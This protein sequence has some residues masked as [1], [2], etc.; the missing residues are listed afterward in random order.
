LLSFHSVKDYHALL[1]NGTVT[2]T[3]AVSFYI[4]NIKD[5]RHLNA[6][7]EVYE[8]EAL[9]QA[10][11]LDAKRQSGK[12]IGK[13]HGVI[14]GLKDVISYKGHALSA[15][16]HILENFQ[17][18]YNATVVERLL[19]EDAIIIGR[20]NCDEFAMGSSNENSAFGPVL[21]AADN[22]R[23]PGGSSGGSAVAVQADLCMVSLGSDTGGSVRQP[24]DFCGIVGLKPSYGRVSRYGLIA[25]GSSF[26]QI[27]IFAKNISDAALVLEIIS[28]KDEYDST[29]VDAHFHYTNENSTDETYRIG[30]FP[31]TFDHPSLDGEIA[32]QQKDFISHLQKSGITVFPIDFDLLDYIVPAYYILTTAEASSNLS[33]YDGIK[34]GVNQPAKEIDDQIN[35]TRSKFFGKEVQRRIMLGTFVLSEGYY[36]AYVTQA[37]RVRN[38]LL[39]KVQSVFSDVDAIIFPVSPTTAFRI[40]EK[41]NDPVEMFLADIYTVFANLT[42]IPAVSIPLFKHSDGMPFGVQVMASHLNELS[43]LTLSEKLLS[44]NRAKE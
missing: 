23:V 41:N 36:D 31:A 8:V 30:Y 18:V 39:K 5:N 12:P 22:S 26:D 42:G 29:V 35:L 3:D 28:G 33:R 2:C 4:Q 6:F 44:I 40:G 15:G 38:I 34:Y 24:A 21:N 17:A 11:L 9:E 13:L 10:A 27:G 25:Y 14:V 19:A 37:Q 16:S 20:Q 7:L 32:R 1:V 43:L